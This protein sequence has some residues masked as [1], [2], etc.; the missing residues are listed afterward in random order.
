[1]VADLFR[2]DKTRPY[3]EISALKPAVTQPQVYSPM[4]SDDNI[5]SASPMYLYQGKSASCSLPNGIGPSARS[6][7]PQVQRHTCHLP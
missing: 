1:M 7:E 4:P 3:M 6:T 2:D 5:A